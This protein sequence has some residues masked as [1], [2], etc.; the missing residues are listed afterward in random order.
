VP[1]YEP[2]PLA[3]A[4]VELLTDTARAAAMGRAGHDKVIQGYR[5]TDVLDRV[6]GHLDVSAAM[7][8][9]VGH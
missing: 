3:D 1:R 2:E 7:D 6:A 5:W 9:R 8:T 4:L